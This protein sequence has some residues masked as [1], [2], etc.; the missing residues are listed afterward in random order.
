MT[1]GESSSLL[2]TP[3]LSLPGWSGRNASLAELCPGSQGKLCVRE[4][5]RKGAISP[6]VTRSTSRAR[7]T[8]GTSQTTDA[9]FA[10]G[11]ISTFGTSIPLKTQKPETS[12]VGQEVTFSILL[13]SGT[14][15]QLMF[16]L[17]GMCKN[18]R[19]FRE[20]RLCGDSQERPGFHPWSP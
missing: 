5:V 10:R 6:L 13:V 19:T 12:G 2:V 20:R 9:I 11:T 1:P 18:L 3:P 16:A 4:K 15:P 7:R 17:P 14:P 8:D